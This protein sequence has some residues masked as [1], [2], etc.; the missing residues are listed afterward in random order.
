VGTVSALGAVWVSKA[1][2]FENSELYRVR[3]AIIPASSLWFPI[4]SVGKMALKISATLISDDPT[5]LLI[6]FLILFS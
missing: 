2:Y 3:S 1:P 6:A 4:P 5:S